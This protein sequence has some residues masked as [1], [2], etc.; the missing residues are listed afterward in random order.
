MS[1]IC[2]RCLETKNDSDFYI[3]NGRY[4]SYCKKCTIKDNRARV[5]NRTRKRIL[6]E[7]PKVRPNMT[8]KRCPRCKLIKSVREFSLSISNADGY[9]A[10]C[11]PCQSEINYGKGH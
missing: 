11:K 10:Y 2:P 9:Y 5:A 3:S 1:R 6:G 7:L 8:I 4:S